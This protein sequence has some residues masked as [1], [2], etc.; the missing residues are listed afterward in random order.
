MPSQLSKRATHHTRRLKGD[1]IEQTCGRSAHQLI[2]QGIPKKSV[3]MPQEKDWWVHELLSA[4]G[5]VWG[6]GNLHGSSC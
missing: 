3:R 1:G 2:N 5:R 4:S 6:T